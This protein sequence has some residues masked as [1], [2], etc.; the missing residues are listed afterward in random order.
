MSKKKGRPTEARVN[1]P[2]EEL[3]TKETIMHYNAV[4]IE[5]QNSKFQLVL[6]RI[7]VLSDK[8]DKFGNRLTTV[9]QTIRGLKDDMIDM[10]RRIC[11]K[12][13]RLIERDDNHE[14]RLAALEAGQ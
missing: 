5:E 3:N 10:E 13:N 6:E 7:D 14:C 1:T 9:E 2:I 11:S 8:V 4:L 12:I